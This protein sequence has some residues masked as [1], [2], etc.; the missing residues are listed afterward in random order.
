MAVDLRTGQERM[1]I[2]H[3]R[4]GEIALNPVDHSLLGVRHENGLATLVRIPPPYDN[5]DKIH[6]FPYGVVLHDLDISPDGRLLS[7][8]VALDNGDHRCGCGSSR[9]F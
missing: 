8:S 6:T 1:L 3:G 7:G 5:W 9:R 2:E 4:I